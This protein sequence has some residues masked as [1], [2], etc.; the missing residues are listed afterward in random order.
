M[1]RPTGAKETLNLVRV[2]RAA[3]GLR[4]HELAQ[5]AGVTRQ[6]ISAIEAGQYVPNTTV[7]LRLAHAL[8]CTVEALFPLPDQPTYV[9]A[10]LI[11]APLGSPEPAMRVRVA[12]VGKRMLAH[13]MRRG[14]DAFTAADGLASPSQRHEGPLHDSTV[15]VELLV[16]RAQLEQAVVVCGCDPAFALLGSHLARRHPSF[17]LV[18]TPQSSLNALQSLA[19]GEAHAAGTHLH[20]PETGDYNVPYVNRELRGQKVVVVTLSEWQEGLIVARGNPKGISGPA[21]LA[22]GDVT[23]LN[24]E[25]GSGSRMFV[26][27]SLSHL[28]MSPDEV[29]GYHRIALSHM[30]VAEMVAAGAVD[31]GPGILSAAHALGLG[32]VALRQERND[33]VVPREFMAYA[34]MRALLDVAVSLPYRKELQSLGGYDSARAGTV[35][36]ELTS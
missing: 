30:A 22:R 31:V 26:D 21:D 29:R 10:E 8:N 4:Q 11:G 16:E 34:P 6:S 15:T 12:R 33:L 3:A 35:V 14:E 27:S 28:G 7:A 24:R 20:D 23:M 17:R 5:V 19:R 36:A 13:P 1:G 18:W 9:D 32:F 2:R 25:V